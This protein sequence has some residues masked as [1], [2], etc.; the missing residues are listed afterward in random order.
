MVIVDEADSLF[1]DSCCRIKGVGPVIGLTATSI[2][3]MHD[4]ERTYMFTDLEFEFV[5]SGMTSVAVEHNVVPLQ[6]YG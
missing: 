4:W 1:L 6:D 3:A 5:S 2:N